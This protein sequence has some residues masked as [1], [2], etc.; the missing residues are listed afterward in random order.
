VQRIDVKIYARVQDVSLNL[1]LPPVSFRYRLRMVFV[2][3]ASHSSSPPPSA[4]AVFPRRSTSTVVLGRSSNQ[5]AVRVIELD[6]PSE[7]FGA[8]ST[9]IQVL[10]FVCFALVSGV[11]TLI[12]FSK[13]SDWR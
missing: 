13:I 8:M 9:S 5:Q 7:R 6:A 2:R 12:F 4:S 11:P 3:D 1:A 10:F